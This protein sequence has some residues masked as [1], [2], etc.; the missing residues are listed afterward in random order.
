MDFQCTLCSKT[1]TCTVPKAA[2]CECGATYCWDE[3]LMLSSSWAA[4]T[5]LT[6]RAELK[7]ACKRFESASFLS[8]ERG[9]LLS[10]LHDKIEEHFGGPSEA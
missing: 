9:A 2:T 1:V 7:A 10:E 8:S 6:L 4:S 5:I 3:G